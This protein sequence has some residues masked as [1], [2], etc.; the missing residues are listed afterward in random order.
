MWYDLLTLHRIEI[1]TFSDNERAIRCYQKC[2]FVEEGRLRKAMWTTKGYREVMMGLLREDW[3]A[4][5]A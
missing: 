4:A 3:E 5:Q 2:G 1:D